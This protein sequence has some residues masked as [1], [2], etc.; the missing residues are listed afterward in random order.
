MIEIDNMYEQS[1]IYGH[2]CENLRLLEKS[3]KHTEISA[4]KAIS[5]KD[6]NNCLS[7]LLRLYAFLLGAWAETRLKKL[8]HEGRGFSKKERDIVLKN[9]KQH[10]QWEN[11]IKN[12][13]RKH[14]KI[15]KLNKINLGELGVA[16]LNSILEIIKNDLK[17][18]I[19]I[20][21]KLAHGQWKYPFT[22][23]GDKVDKEK[24]CLINKENLLSLKFKYEI[25]EHLT[26]VIHDL[27]VSKVTFERDFE[28]HFK[29]LNQT[30]MNLKK[31][32]YQKYEDNLIKAFEVSKYKKYKK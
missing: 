7:T 30:K 20:R 28:K 5:S 22:D 29:K 26:E 8:L 25:L 32:S 19:E 14:Y 6:K 27:I 3:L 23:N 9:N 24:Y 1:K 21:N 16:R 13:F 12:A 2:H 31:R 11:T 17:I 15:S 18:I 10:I 4:K